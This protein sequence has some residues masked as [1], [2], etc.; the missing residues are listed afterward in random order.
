MNNF[1]EWRAEVQKQLILKDMT[2]KDLAYAIEY[3][4]EYVM[5]IAS[6]RRVGRP[7]MDAISRYLGVPP[8]RYAPED[9]SLMRERA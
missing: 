8:Y 7:C 2:M 3:N 9:V 4:Y 5:S 1:R 6:G